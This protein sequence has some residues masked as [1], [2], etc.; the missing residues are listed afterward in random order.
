MRNATIAVAVLLAACSTTPQEPRD[1]TTPTEAVRPS[2]D[3]GDVGCAGYANQSNC[4]SW[5]R[6]KERWVQE[7][8]ALYPF[9]TNKECLVLLG[10]LT[11]A[12][13]R[14]AGI[15]MKAAYETRKLDSDMINAWAGCAERAAITAAAVRAW[16]AQRGNRSGTAPR[17]GR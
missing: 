8:C 10:G 6:S 17:A 13:A 2:K 3:L 9:D 4:G 1:P 12:A 16:D 14:Q 11:W 5:A 15:C 7:Q